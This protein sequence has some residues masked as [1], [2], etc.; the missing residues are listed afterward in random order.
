[1]WS[2]SLVPVW[3]PLKSTPHPHPH[4][5]TGQ[6]EHGWGPPQVLIV[7]WDKWPWWQKKSF[8]GT[9]GDVISEVI[10][11]RV[12]NSISGGR[13]GAEGSRGESRQVMGRETE[14]RVLFLLVYTSKN[15]FCIYLYLF[16]IGRHMHVKILNISY[17]HTQA[18]KNR[19]IP[20]SMG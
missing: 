11:K 9:G 12:I 19:F 18:D 1:M 6:Q 14:G 8:Q 16:L 10:E 13:G 17:M 4:P 3:D 2:K 5:L 15:K 7:C 20:L